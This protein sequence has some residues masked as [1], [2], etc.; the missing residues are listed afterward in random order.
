MVCVVAPSRPQHFLAAAPPF[1]GLVL[2]HAHTHPLRRG[3]CGLLQTSSCCPSF[4]GFPNNNLIQTLARLGDALIIILPSSLFLFF[5][6][7]EE[8]G[9]ASV[10]PLAHAL[11]HLLRALRGSSCALPQWAMGL[12]CRTAAAAVPFPWMDGMHTCAPSS[13]TFSLVPLAPTLCGS[14][15]WRHRTCQAACCFKS[16]I[17]RSSGAAVPQPKR[18][19]GLWPRCTTVHHVSGW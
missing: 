2:V 19:Q 3:P 15:A 6:R 10:A 16:S 4:P 5:A 1:V 17:A 13:T 8:R 18:G 7:P 11:T 12:A 14:A 9:T